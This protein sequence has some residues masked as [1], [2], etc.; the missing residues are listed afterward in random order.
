MEKG[1]AERENERRRRDLYSLLCNSSSSKLIVF[2][3]SWCS[4]WIAWRA[5]SVR[6]IQRRG[7]GKYNRKGNQ[8]RFVEKF[9]VPWTHFNL[10][11][12]H[13]VVVYKPMLE[14]R[15][16]HKYK[17]LEFPPVSIKI[18]NSKFLCEII[19]MR[20]YIFFYLCNAH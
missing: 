6:I 20:I 9:L 3:L 17:I 5:Y 4:T 1:T 15:P 16:R 19:Y 18:I 10:Y 11:Q 2:E 13:T 7:I 8:N 14:I 12:N